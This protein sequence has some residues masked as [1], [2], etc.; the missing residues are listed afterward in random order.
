MRGPKAEPRRV[1]G[2]GIATA[3]TAMTMKT[4]RQRMRLLVLVFTTAVVSLGGGIASVLA[5]IAVKPAETGADTCPVIRAADT[6]GVRAAAEF[7]SDDQPSEPTDAKQPKAVGK[8]AGFEPA[9][10]AVLLRIVFTRPAGAASRLI[11][12]A[13]STAAVWLIRGPPRGD[14]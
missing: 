7:F 1:A 11:G 2:S 12:P 13:V 8:F 4:V 14:R 5:L 10:A 3:N 9:E 6:G